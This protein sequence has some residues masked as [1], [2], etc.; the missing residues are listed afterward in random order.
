MGDTSG[1]SICLSLHSDAPQKQLPGRN[2]LVEVIV[3]EDF[4]HH[5]EASS[6]SGWWWLD[7][8]QSEPGSRVNLEAGW[9]ITLKVPPSPPLSQPGSTT[10][11]N[12]APTWGRTVQT[13]V[14]G[15]SI[16]YPTHGI[17]ES[18]TVRQMDNPAKLWSMGPE[19][20]CQVFSL[21]GTATY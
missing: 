3:S 21:I 11:L 13:Q 1:T 9:T 8:S 18:V 5:Q 2:A 10:S 12:T 16:L 17:S 14:C 6:A 4:T 19:H 15:E 20:Y 7:T